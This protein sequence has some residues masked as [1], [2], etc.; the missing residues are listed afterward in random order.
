MSG[1]LTQ[2]SQSA[3][4]GIAQWVNVGSA[5]SPISGAYPGTDFMFLPSN[6]TYFTALP[7]G[8]VTTG[9]TLTTLPPSG[10]RTATSLACG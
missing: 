7:A 5:G 8:A 6:T 2:G 9:S 3:Y 4:G 10:R 1:S